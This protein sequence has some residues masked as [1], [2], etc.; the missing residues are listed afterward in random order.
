MI[1]VGLL[2][3]VLLRC[4]PA[5]DGVVLVPFSCFNSSG[6]HIFSFNMHLFAMVIEC[7]NSSATSTVVVPLL[8]LQHHFQIWYKMRHVIYNPVHFIP[9]HKDNIPILKLGTH[10]YFFPLFHVEPKLLLSL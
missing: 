9:R 6:L 3:R 8:A 7:R 4:G 2:K 1:M 5:P 10:S